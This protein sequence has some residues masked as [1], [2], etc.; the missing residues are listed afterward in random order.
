MNIKNLASALLVAAALL[1]PTIAKAQE[2]VYLPII[3]NQP[4]I[5]VTATIH[6]IVSD[7][8][9]KSV[10]FWAGPDDQYYWTSI[11]NGDA[12]TIA[13]TIGK[14]VTLG[15]TVMDGRGGAYILGDDWYIT[16]DK[17]Q[18]VIQLNLKFNMPG[19]T[20]TLY[21]DGSVTI[22]DSH[23]RVDVCLFPDNG[24]TPEA[25]QP[26]IDDLGDGRYNI[27]VGN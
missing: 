27:Y 14:T 6:S 22:V 3:K 15:G 19:Q 26:D 12:Q 16:K 2:T 5:K 18:R 10:I 24:C 17:I 21:E 20:Y 8:E 1:V 11:S 4:R 13:Q 9:T 23:Q 7:P 25:T